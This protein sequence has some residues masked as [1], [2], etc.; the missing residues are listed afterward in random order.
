LKHQKHNDES[1]HRRSRLSSAS[2]SSQE[3]LAK[4]PCPVEFFD[5]ES[6]A[7]KAQ[8]SLLKNYLNIDFKKNKE[9]VS[10][11]KTVSLV[12]GLISEL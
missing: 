10:F 5:Q 1:E 12:A 8:D 6:S 3:D 11:Q 9:S 7:I 4:T 2:F